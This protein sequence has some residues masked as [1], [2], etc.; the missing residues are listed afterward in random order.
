MNEKPH[1]KRVFFQLPYVASFIGVLLIGGILGVQFITQTNDGTSS[2]D[3][4]IEER[5][6]Q[7]ITNE[8]IET[9]INEI[10]GYYER[11]LDELKGKLKFEEVEQYGFIQEAKN[12]VEKFEARK[13][14]ASH[15]ELT[16]YM[17]KVKEIITYRVS[18]PHEEFEL[19]QESAAN[20]EKISNDQVYA[21]IDKLDMLHEQFYEQ[22]LKSYTKNQQTITDIE[23]Y[24]NELNAGTIKTGDQEYSEF[25]KALKAN[26][27]TFFHEGEGGINFTPDYTNVHN[28]LE[29]ALNVDAEVYLKIKSEKKALIDG[30]LAISHKNLGER[31]LEIEDFVLNN[32][33]SPKVEEL[34]EQYVLY[35]SFYLK[36]SNNTMIVT[37]DGTIKPEIKRNYESLI[38]ENEFSETAKIVEKFYQRL[39]EAQFKL[40]SEL[41]ASEIDVSKELKPKSEEY[42]MNIYLLPITNE[43]KAR[44]EDF[45][46]SGDMGIFDQPFTGANSIELA[47]ARIYMYA[48]EKGDYE[49]SN[50]LLINGEN[51]KL[52]EQEA[53]K[54]ERPESPIDFQTLSNEVSKVTTTYRQ[55][56]EVIEHIFIKENGEM[57]TFRMRLEN[58]YPKIEHNPL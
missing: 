13:N 3:A 25:S 15:A 54:K 47:V 37:E 18:M 19:L 50:N 51:A 49:T 43:M 38:T 8:D 33:V 24:V 4:P 26:G 22:W 53:L 36:G 6:N 35:M 40:T 41:R 21:Y 14:Y 12:A 45:K 39:E 56:G 29:E 48:V 52:P 16:S 1:K 11:R 10:R 20:G 9:A 34:K 32:P 28:Q 23:S 2:K 55:D 57:V 58:G 46:V 7:P 42:S 44:Y 5:N 31:L 17:E 27:Y 30:A